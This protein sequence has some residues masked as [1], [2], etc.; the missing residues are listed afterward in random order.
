[1]K[2]ILLVHPKFP[3][4]YWG[5]QDAMRVVNK[6]AA[7]PP[8]GLITL[9]ACLPKSW[10]L[11]LVD[12]NIGQLEE[13]DIEW[14][15]VV[16][17]GGMLVQLESMANVIS[18]ARQSGR[19]VVVGGPA[20]TTSPE[21]FPNV[22][23]IFQGEAEGR[24]QKLVDAIETLG[25]GKE[26]LISVEDNYPDLT[27]LPL[28]RFD[29]LDLDQYGSMAIQYSRGCPFSCEFCDIIEIFGRV[30]RVKTQEQILKELDEIYG[31]GFKG[32]VFFVDDNFIGNKR[33]VRELLP[34]ITDWQLAH[35]RPFDIYTEAS[36]NLASDPELMEGMVQAGFRS[37]FI[38]IETP[39]KKALKN[40]GKGQNL[41]IDLKQ[42]VN[43]LTKAGIEVMGGFIVGFDQESPE[44]FE[45]QRA[46]IQSSPIPFAMVGILIALPGTALRRRLEKEGRIRNE[47]L[48]DQ[49]GR[50]NFVP[51]MDEAVLLQ[52]YADLMR[53]LYSPDAYYRRCE[54][55][56]SQAG[57]I[58]I[59]G[60]AGLGDI[61]N[62]LKIAY[63]VGIKSPRRR[64][65][66]R[67][68]MRTIKS[69]PHTFRWSVV[70]AL[71]GEHMIRYT[72][73]NV[74]PRIRSAIEEIGLERQNQKGE[75]R[76]FD[77][78][79]RPP[80]KVVPQPQAL[81]IPM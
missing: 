81:S 54:D 1:M 48:G 57:N 75:Q 23:I 45:A 80:L 28:P 25:N 32:S 14:A 68:L 59:G 8:L 16:F 42:A 51:S 37:V 17:V 40:T 76:D 12:L 67:L 49:F 7:L 77:L 41:R 3:V 55:Y 15:D 53:D 74:L 60:T 64:H 65:F 21:L 36:I 4:T 9:A 44:I 22:D 69:A 39:S 61:K 70:K 46:F 35:D 18:R 13:T 50:T 31:L 29:L 11:R 2:K 34:L 62:L 33:A 47:T 56:V 24:A 6:R 52:G 20:A 5:F 43:T 10:C 78:E 58:P 79:I 72:E 63:Y 30:P 73:E 66:W 27:N 38:G 19:P 26:V 71:Q